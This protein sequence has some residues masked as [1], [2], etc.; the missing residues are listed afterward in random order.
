MKDANDPEF[1]EYEELFTTFSPADRAV[2]KSILEAENIT[3][4]LQG[5]HATTYVYNALPVRLM[6]RKDQ[7]EKAREILQ[8]FDTKSTFSGIDYLTDNED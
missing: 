6:V 7:A 1:I 8:D 4:F 5:E 2:L 3:Y